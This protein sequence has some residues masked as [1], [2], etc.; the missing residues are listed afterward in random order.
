MNFKIEKSSWLTLEQRRVWEHPLLQI[1]MV[2]RI[3]PGSQPHDFI[4]LQ[5]PDWVNVVA[6]TE[7]EQV[8]L[9]H[10]FR[11]GSNDYTLELPGGLVDPGETPGQAGIRELRE[12]TGFQAEDI[13][14]LG[15]VNPNPALFTNTCHT[16]LVPKAKPQ[17]QIIMGETERTQVVLVPKSDL[18]DL[19]HS[20]EIT[21]SLV[22]S[23]LTFFWLRENLLSGR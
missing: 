14:P 11:Q 1:D 7:D 15:Q 16:F 13:I 19:V 3:P 22:I 17:G 6:L 23:A 10:Q 9:V 21:H 8:I 18:P 20:G 5:A 12:E 2:Q 4:V